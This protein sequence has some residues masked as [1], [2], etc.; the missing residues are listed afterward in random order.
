MAYLLALTEN[1]LFSRQLSDG[2][3]S[4]FSHQPKKSW[5]P[6]K[7][8]PWDL[9]KLQHT[10]V[11]ILDFKILQVFFKNRGELLVFQKMLNFL[12]FLGLLYVSGDF[13]QKKKFKFFSDWWKNFDHSSIHVVYLQNFSI[14]QLER[15]FN[16][17]L[18]EFFG[19]TLCFRTFQAKKKFEIFFSTDW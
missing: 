12:S 9:G 8:P 14:S 5:F 11:N 4:A 10:R 19:F 3:L 2:F 13:K 15:N 1:R 18:L 16:F 17:F 7:P 6:W